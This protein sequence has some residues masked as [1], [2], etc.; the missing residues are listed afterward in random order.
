MRCG[1]VPSPTVLRQRRLT[2]S[3]SRAASQPEALLA[4]SQGIL[5]RLLDWMAVVSTT[6]DLLAPIAQR[7]DILEVFAYS[8]VSNGQGEWHARQV[9]AAPVPSS[10]V[11]TGRP[12]LA[13][14]QLV[15]FQL[16]DRL[17][18]CRSCAWLELPPGQPDR[19]DCQPFKDDVLIDRTGEPEHPL[20]PA[21][22]QRGD[23][24]PGLLHDPSIRGTGAY[25]LWRGPCPWARGR[26]H[27]VDLVVQIGGTGRIGC[28]SESGGEVPLLSRGVARRRQASGPVPGQRCRRTIR[29]RSTGCA[30][31]RCLREIG[32]G[33][34]KQQATQASETSSRCLPEAIT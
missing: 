6:C 17:G 22:G 18:S 2:H 20:L 32:T 26:P 12:S 10:W 33:P 25:M 28:F 5:S 9:L 3:A 14:S 7:P 4:G 15:R 29:S 8:P 24:A 34:Y 30:A 21:A 16:A 19:P 31:F 23:L 13:A 1:S 11:F 27:R